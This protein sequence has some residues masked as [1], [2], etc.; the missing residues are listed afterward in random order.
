GITR[1]RGLGDS[2]RTRGQ[3]FLDQAGEEAVL[4]EGARQRLSARSE[5]ILRDLVLRDIREDPGWYAG[6]LLRRVGATLTLRK[7]WPWG[8]W[9]G[10]SFAPSTAPEEGVTDNYYQLTAQADWLVLG[11]PPLQLPPAPILL[12]PPPPP[13][14]A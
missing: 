6:I 13:P 3:V 1:G 4:R 14:P 9:G 11:G 12:P 10:R 7:L 2:D 5:A 8:P